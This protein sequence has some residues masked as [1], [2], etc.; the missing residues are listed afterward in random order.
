MQRE[1]RKRCVS[2][3]LF[4]ATMKLSTDT[5]IISTVFEGMV[6]LRDCGI[7]NASILY[8]GG[9]AFSFNRSD[10]TSRAVYDPS[11]KRGGYL[12]HPVFNAFGKTSSALPRDTGLPLMAGREYHK[13]HACVCETNSHPKPSA[14]PILV[15]RT[16]KFRS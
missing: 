10:M 9:A 8:Q 3:T 2:S 16:G 14:M 5:S 15:N 6:G 1:R 11:R 13:F 4:V 7:M 12:H